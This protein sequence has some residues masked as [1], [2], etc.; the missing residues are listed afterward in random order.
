MLDV[1]NPPVYNHL[2]DKARAKSTLGSFENGFENGFNQIN[3]IILKEHNL[4]S[5]NDYS[6]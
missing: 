5:R 4:S 2:E 1:P 3:K 6:S